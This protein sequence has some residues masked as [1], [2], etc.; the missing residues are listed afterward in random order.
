VIEDGMERRD[1]V[2]SRETRLSREPIGS[3]SPNSTE[4]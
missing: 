3:Q 1:H 2:I 4:V